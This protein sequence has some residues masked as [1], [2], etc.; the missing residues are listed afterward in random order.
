MNVSRL[1]PGTGQVRVEHIEIPP[2]VQTDGSVGPSDGLL[3]T[4]TA[5]LAIEDP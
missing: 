5:T 1:Q 3:T 4:E 2:G